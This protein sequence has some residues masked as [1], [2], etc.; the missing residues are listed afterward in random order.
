MARAL[1]AAQ[2]PIIIDAEGV[3]RDWRADLAKAILSRQRPDGSWVNPQDRWMEGHD[4]LATVYA[5]LALEELLKPA[6][7]A[8]LRRKESAAP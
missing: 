5:V 1:R 8:S 3:K 6:P 2:Q 7:L 4:E